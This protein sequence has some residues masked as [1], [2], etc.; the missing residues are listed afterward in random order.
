M[1]S[2]YPSVVDAILQDFS[3]LPNL[4]ELAHVATRLL[5]AALLGGALGFER[6]FAGKSAGLRTHMLVTVG[7][8]LFVMVP[9]LEGMDIA[10]QSRVWQ[11]IITGIGFLGAGAIL[12]LTQEQQIHGLTTAAG[13][14]LA[15]AVG[16][17][18]GV[19]R[20][21]TAMLATVLAILILS[22][23]GWIEQ[24]YCQRRGI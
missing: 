20:S 16:I 24:R 7:V 1:D 14:W 11:G 15:A 6:E 3:D 22:A 5:M 4:A 23:A 12:K 18:V 13:I 9:Q 21:G 8:A 17:A 10:D 2:S 19:G